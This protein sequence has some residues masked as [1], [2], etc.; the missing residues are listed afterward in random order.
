MYCRKRDLFRQSPAAHQPS[1]PY[2]GRNATRR[3]PADQTVRY[4]IVRDGTDWKIDGIQRRRATVDP[5][6]ARG[7]A[8]ELEHDPEKWKPVFR[9]DHAQNKSNACRSAGRP[10]RIRLLR[11]LGEFLIAE[12][13]VLP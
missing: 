5:R 7:V 9:K 1:D 13:P 8:D 2:A 11:V 4:D 12:P 10:D 6:H 3:K